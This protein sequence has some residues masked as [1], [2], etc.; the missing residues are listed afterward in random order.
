[1]ICGSI[2]GFFHTNEVIKYEDNSKE[3]AELNA[4]FEIVS[5]P[6][7]SGRFLKTYGISQEYGKILLNFATHSDII[8]GSILQVKCKLK[9]PKKFNDFDY[10][11]YLFMH[12]VNYICNVK[13]YEL[14]GYDN[15][16]LNEIASVRR[17]LEGNISKMMP[18][19]ESGLANGL[20]FGGD[21]RLSEELQNSFA[22]TGMSH[23]VAVSG[24]NVSVI[25]FTIIIVGI[26][27]GFWRKQAALLSVVAVIIFVTMI[28]FPASGVRAAIMGTIVLFAVVFGRVVNS[29]NLVVISCTVMLLWS[30]L[31][32]RYDVGFQL[33]FLAVIG[34]LTIYPIFEK[35]IVIKYK[36]F[37]L[38]EILFLTISA[39]LFV[40]PIIIINFH[41]FSFSSVLTNLLILPILPLTMLLVFFASILS[42]I[43]FS[44][45]YPFVWLAYLLLSYEIFMIE[46]FANQKWSSVVV[47]NFPISLSALY[48]LALFS[49]IYYFKDRLEV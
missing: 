5:Q 25:V 48:Y 32:I 10:P 7:S 33:S 9:S 41:I 19:P 31:Q 1:M 17:Q 16:F 8:R 44:I 34:I 37:T 29:L 2:Y 23:I 49:I 14:V 30:P 40:L 35:L 39:Q 12:R 45:A 47:E 36:V 15:N 22:I 43:S 6:T 13:S 21:D 42:I 24:Y 27:I 3:G 11:K 20:I 46:F 18:A 38:T 28:G 26:F 4:K